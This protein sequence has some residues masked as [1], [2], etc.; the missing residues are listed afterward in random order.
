M[1]K[2][3]VGIAF[4][5]IL[6]AGIGF[7]AFFLGFHMQERLLMKSDR[8]P[9]R[10]EMQIATLEVENEA[11]TAQVAELQKQIET[12]VKAQA[13]RAAQAASL[14]TRLREAQAELEK[15]KA[16]ADTPPPAPP[17]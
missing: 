5:I 11:L 1:K 8:N 3:L 9:T 6:A 17:L 2:A 16:R 15:L 13:D 10:L 4:L 7:G 14:E 12:G